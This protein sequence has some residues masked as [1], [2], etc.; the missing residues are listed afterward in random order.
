MPS[1]TADIR[2]PLAACAAAIVETA[3]ELAKLGWTPATSSNFSMRLDATRM[4]ITASGRDKGKLTSDDILALD[5]HTEQ[6]LDTALK[7]SAETLLHTQI[8]RRFPE[9]GAILHTHSRTQSVASRLFA[10]A[11]AVHLQGWELQKA[12][13]GFDTH[14]S[15]LT[16]PVFPNSQHMPDLAAH[17]DA[18][19][20]AGKP[21]HAYLVNGHGMYAWGRDM[22]EARRQLEALDF[23]LDCELDLRRLTT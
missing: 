5:I 15:V 19:L 2:Q 9:T 3:A 12:I 13:T 18:W 7:P 16:I 4:A 14:E 11:G 20:E 21:L 17:V 1:L 10:G 23:L 8:Y 6:P 22:A